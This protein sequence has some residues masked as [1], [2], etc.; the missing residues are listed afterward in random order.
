MNLYLFSTG[1][2]LGMFITF[3][4]MKWAFRK[5]FGCKYPNE[6]KRKIQHLYDLIE[7]SRA[8]REKYQNFLDMDEKM[9]QKYEVK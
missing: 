7:Q 6:L 1:F 4:A 3:E 2:V 5:K 9:K 8:E